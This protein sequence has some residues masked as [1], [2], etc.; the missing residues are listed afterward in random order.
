M[1]ATVLGL[2]EAGTLYSAGLVKLGWTVT[3]YD[4]ADNATPSGV[5]R[6]ASAEEAI[7]GADAV[8]SLV[9]GKAAVA[10]ADSVAPFLE[11]DAVYA[12]MNAGD[13]AVKRQ[14][15][16]KVGAHRIADAS[17]IGTCPA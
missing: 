6:A 10:A 13:P 15:A 11:A 7:R 9:G 8:L 17:V 4:P 16:A 3:G 2:G 12:D 1:R 14:I 5:G